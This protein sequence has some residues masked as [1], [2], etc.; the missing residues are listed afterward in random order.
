VS[1]NSDKALI[2]KVPEKTSRK[3]LEEE[4]NENKI[5]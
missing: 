2:F 5:C 1:L 4:I 3:G